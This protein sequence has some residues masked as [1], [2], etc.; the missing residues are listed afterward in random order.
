[1]V[2]TR[3]TAPELPAS[4]PGS[5][6]RSPLVP[7]LRKN[8]HRHP[9]S[10]T[11]HYTKWLRASGIKVSS[12]SLKQGRRRKFSPSTRTN[13]SFNWLRWT[14]PNPRRT[15]T[16]LDGGSIPCTAILKDIGRWKSAATGGWRL[17]L[18]IKM[19]CSWTI[20]T[21][22]ERF[23]CACTIRRIREVFYGN[24]LGPCRSQRPPGTL[25]WRGL[26]CRASWMAAPESRPPRRWSCPMRSALAP[27]C[28]SACRVSLI[29]GERHSDNIRG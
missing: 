16:R 9:Y 12:S 27:N 10:D 14:M 20:R 1:L 8:A 19:P 3:A 25:G 4:T 2:S 24:I 13:C 21:I 5:V 26:R 22:T 23:L 7:P 15:W 11:I 17:C 6:R 29:C 18:K 28:G